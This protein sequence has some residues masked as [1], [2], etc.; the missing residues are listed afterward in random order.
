ML[1]DKRKILVILLLIL[2]CV[3]AIV[4]KL[5][6]NL[7]IDEKVYS[8]ISLMSSDI[9][10]AFF[11]AITYL[12]NVKFICCFC[13]ILLFINKTRVKI[14]IPLSI[15]TIMSGILNV[16]L[17]NIF[18]RQRP[19]IE[20]LVYEDSFSFPSGHS[21]II[22]TIYVMII[23]LSCRYIKSK[24]IKYTVNIISG[25]IIVLVG[26]SRIYLRVHY[27]SDVF[28]GWLLGIIIILVYSIFNDKIE[29]IIKQR[30]KDV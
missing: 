29:K 25:L 10:T 13:L 30:I 16:I 15:V 11:K 3:L 22:A 7:V 27:F 9:A 4:V 23:Y 20:Q 26:I 12:G 17:K 8:F 24:K 18:E 14:G 6:E 21:M 2:F 5:K 19:L 28:A 1:K